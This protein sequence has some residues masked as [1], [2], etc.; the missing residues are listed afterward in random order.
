MNLRLPKLVLLLFLL[1]VVSVVSGQG[2]DEVITVIKNESYSYTF[3][4]QYQPS[5]GS[6]PSNGTAT[7][8]AGDVEF[9]YTLTYT[10]NADFTGE[11]RLLLVNFPFGFNV[12]FE[13]FNFNVAE[14]EVVCRQDFAATT[15]GNSVTIA[16]ADNDESNVGTLE[17]TAVPVVNAGTAEIVDGQIVFTPAPGFS[18]LTDLNYVS[19]VG[20]VCD[21]GTVSINVQP[22]N[23]DSAQDTLQVFTTAAGQFIFAPDGAVPLTTP[24]HGRMI[25]S[26]GVMAY[27]PD[28]DFLGEELLEY[29]VI[30]STDP[31]VFKVTTLDVT[32]NNFAVEDRGFTTVGNSTTIN[33]LHNDLYSVFADC[34][35]F[36]APQ[37]G[38]LTEGNGNG[39][40]TNTP[41]AGCSGVEQFTYSSKAPGCEGESEVETVYV[42]VSN[43][44]PR[45]GVT[46]LT[47]AAG[48][49]LR[50][51]YDVPGGDATWSVVSGPTNG[52]IVTDPVNGH[53]SY[54]PLISASGATDA[55]TLRYCLN[56]SSP[57]DCDFSAEVPV[58]VQVTAEDANACVDEDCVWPGDTNNDGVVDVGDLLPIGLA[59]GQ[60]GTPRLSLEPTGWSAQYGENWDQDLNGVDLKHVD[61]NGDQIISSLDTQVVMAN[62]G[63]AHRITPTPQTFAAFELSLV[64]SLEA[65]PGDLVILDI[66][67]GNSVV[68]T[69]DFYG[70]TLPFEYD[71]ETIDPASV[72]VDFGENS[73]FSYDSPIL[74]ISSNNT[75]AGTI[76]TALTRTNGESISGFGKIGTMSV[77]ITEDFYGFFDTYEGEDGFTA[78]ERTIN[79]GAGGKTALA[80][81]G[82]GHLDAV[83]VNPHQLTV[84]RRPATDATAFTPSAATSFL[85]EKLQVYP[86]PTADRLSVHLNGQQRFSA[87]RLTDLIGRTVLTE[88]GL[89]TNHRELLLGQVPNG[90]YT[91]TL[92]TGAGVVNR[93]VEVL[94]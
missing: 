42:F 79:F 43:F 40:V 83:R 73:W 75:D 11:D 44:A 38:S 16:V 57:R 74:S 64:G 51:T 6:S 50:I 22:V 55:F 18:G 14:A 41:P 35:T 36:G 71:T 25:D 49:P 8:T 87:L 61:A 29:S 4:S 77:V 5:V 27:V 33:V 94:R 9:S 89:D 59:I 24:E 93:K 32:E 19:C 48:T 92:T 82:A 56:G 39:Q 84:K 63:L 34:V 53:L 86:N 13:W 46:E 66:L 81:N 65:E 80:M 72:R 78:Q 85:D 3:L 10:P 90:I 45:A 54:L 70:F 37:F 47:T 62:L 28:T 26:N 31:L 2:G 88:E 17:L 30:G 12:S 21:L 20:T 69:E 91:L 58:T 1:S 23:P 15:A 52:A 7:L 76:N 60:S 68:I 67:A